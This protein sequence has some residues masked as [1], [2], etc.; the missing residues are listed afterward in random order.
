MCRR[1]VTMKDNTVALL[2]WRMHANVLLS[3]SFHDKVM[4]RL[5]FVESDS[6]PHLRPPYFE[7]GLILAAAE[8][9]AQF[10]AER[11]MVVAPV[12]VAAVDLQQQL[13]EAYVSN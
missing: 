6:I 11:W 9:Q 5:P 4:K 13:V 3:S 1:I 8:Y 2:V 10:Q 7:L 12:L